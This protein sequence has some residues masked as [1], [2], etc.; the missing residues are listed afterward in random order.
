M[1]GCDALIGPV[2]I[3][4]T[5]VAAGGLSV[6]FV[7]I[8]V[9]EQP[10]QGGAHLVEG[11]RAD[12]GRPLLFD[13]CYAVTGMCHQCTSAFGQAD[14]FGAAVAGIGLTLQVAELLE[15]VD[16]LGG[17]GQAQLRAGGDVGEAHFTHADRSEDL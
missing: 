5:P 12:D 6:C 16:E 9:V 11:L 3:L 10:L 4:R 7:G 15:V 13:R 1:S 2:F 14:E 8:H 17:G